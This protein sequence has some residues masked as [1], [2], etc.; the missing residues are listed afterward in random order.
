MFGNTQNP[1]GQPYKKVVSKVEQFRTLSGHIME[2]KWTQE[3]LLEN[4]VWQELD[5]FT[6]DPPLT[7]GRIPESIADIR[8]CG[9]CELLFHKETVFGPCENC[10]FYYCHGCREIIKIKEQEVQLC[11]R[12]ANEINES[13]FSKIQNWFSMK[14]E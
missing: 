8:Q 13:W 4:G 7:D 1:L 9:V 12:C 5:L 3:G 14:E 11:S 2:I 10:G 6:V